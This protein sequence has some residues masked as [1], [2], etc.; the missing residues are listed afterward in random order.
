M[1]TIDYSKEIELYDENVP[2]T[3]DAYV[4]RLHNYRRSMSQWRSM[5]L[6]TLWH[7]TK[8]NVIP[9]G[10]AR[11]F[12][13]QN[14]A[15]ILGHY[16]DN[17]DYIKALAGI[18]DI[19]LLDMMQMHQADETYLHEETTLMIQPEEIV[20]NPLAL[21][22][23]YTFKGFYQ[24]TK[25][26]EEDGV[27]AF[28]EGYEIRQTLLNMFMSKTRVEIKA[29]IDEVRADIIKEENDG[30]TP[31]TVIATEFDWDEDEKAIVTLELD[32]TAFNWLNGVLNKKYAVNLYAV[33]GEDVE[34]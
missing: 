2:T 4:R 10:K 34:D 25:K 32:K 3:P 5:L 31:V 27:M 12:V 16:S 30:V 11:D 26:W 13:N 23:A 21:T 24:L 8:T 22:H 33:D 20:F 19:I 15:D 1:P 9:L 14:M 7:G 29:F 6:Y 17:E 18:V 28:D